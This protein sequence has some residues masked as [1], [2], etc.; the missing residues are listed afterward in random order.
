M[1]ATKIE[2]AITP[3]TKAIVPVHYAGV[4]CDMDAIMDIAARHDLVVI[5][6]AAQGLLADYR[7]RPLGGIGHLAALSFHETKNIISGEG[8]A[9]LDQRSAVRRTR[10]GRLGEGHQPE[11]V[12]PR[13][14]RQVHVG[15]PRLVVPARR[16]HRR[17]PLGA[18]GGVEQHHVSPHGDLGHVPRGV[19]ASWSERATCAGR[20]CRPDRS[21]N[22]HMY[23]LLLPDLA[24][25]TAFIDRLKANDIQSVF[26][27]IPLHSS[28]FGRSAGRSARRHVGDG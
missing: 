9:L 1:D 7:G 12:L 25:R 18:D 19:R 24:R 26:H 8:G 11:P 22:A 15:R 13:P 17:L 6:D 28:P 21:H 14:G 5:E 27:Y 10:R 23:Y 4:G 3:R 20:S 16:D 2:A